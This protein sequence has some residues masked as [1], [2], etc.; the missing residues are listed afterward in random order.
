MEVK[1]GQDKGQK[2]HDK[3]RKKIKRTKT[4]KEDRESKRIVGKS[5]Y[6]GSLLQKFFSQKEA[7]FPNKSDRAKCKLYG[8]T[9]HYIITISKDAIA[10][11]LL[12]LRRKRDTQ[13]QIVR[14]IKKG[15]MVLTADQMANILK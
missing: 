9:R 10:A 4:P 12:Y 13:L 14:E 8:L 2:R 15:R 6:L 7:V 11:T 3:L 1:R 5:S